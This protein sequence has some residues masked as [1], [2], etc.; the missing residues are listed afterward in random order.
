MSRLFGLTGGIA[1]GK[2]LVSDIFSDLGAKVVDADIVA[3]QVV[4]KD[5]EGLGSLIKCFGKEL[6]LESGDLNRVALGKIIFK[7]EAARKK[8]NAI[9]HPLI[10][11]ESKMQ[12]QKGFA[13]GH[14]PIVYSA[15]LLIENGLH[16]SMN[17]VILVI[18]PEAI[19]LKR[20]CLR[21]SISE[22]EAR[23]KIAAQMP[24]DEKIKVATQ[25]IDNSGAKGETRKLVTLL[26][27]ELSA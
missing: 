24:Q 9:V 12:I 17:E 7:D 16:S 10:A 2:S 23:T 27:E 8:L 14:D 26:W 4:A 11:V 22:D 3:R 13:A 19:Q 1:T 21:D 18:V 15:A 25:I 20:L 5:S 6:L